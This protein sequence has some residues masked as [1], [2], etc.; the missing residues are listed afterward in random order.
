MAQRKFS[1][2]ESISNLW[3]K[4]D[5]WMDAVILKVPNFILA[6]IVMVAFVFIAKGV[7]RIAEKVMLKNVEDLSMR[8]LLSKLI[9]AIIL[10]VGFFVFLG[11]LQL[12]KVLTS[13]LAG[14]G[15]MG[16]AIGFALQGTL[17]NTA[18]GFML[19]FQPKMRIGDYIDSQGNTGFV[20]EINLI[21]V[22]VRQPDNDFIIIP[23]KIFAEN[24]F[25]N[26]SWTERSRISVNCGVGYEDDLQKVEDLVVK[27]I[28][29]NFEQEENESV[30]FFF[31]EFGDSSINLDRKS[32]V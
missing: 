21:S 17:S 27:I 20:E 14:A 24:P 26:Y 9:Y 5:G 13:V 6:I 3:D 12:D 19:S 32:V 25:V 23:N 29:E 2:S 15:V 31:T 16:L 30:E 22:T 8:H 11:I 28:S 10:L 1:L 7:R 18:S 4:L